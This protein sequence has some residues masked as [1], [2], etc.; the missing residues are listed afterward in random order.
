M[1]ARNGMTDSVMKNVN[2]NNQSGEKNSRRG[3]TVCDGELNEWRFALTRIME[4]QMKMLTLTTLRNVTKSA[5]ESQVK[6]ARDG[7]RRS[8]G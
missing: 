4:L 2:A 8:D 5:R 3:M 7:N 6:T 1:T